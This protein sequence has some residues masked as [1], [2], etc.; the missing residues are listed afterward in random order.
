MFLLQLEAVR[1]LLRG[2]ALGILGAFVALLLSHW[3]ALAP[4]ERGSCNALFR[5]RGPRAPQSKIVLLVVD[6]ATAVRA[7]RMPLPRRY[8]AQ[9]VQKL[10]A[11]GARVIAFNFVFGTPSDD[12]R[13][14]AL[15]ARTV[16]IQNDVTQGLIFD[17]PG[18]V[19]SARA[20]QLL[21]AFS[22]ADRGAGARLALS[23]AAPLPAMMSAR[24]GI[25][26]LNF[27]PEPGGEVRRLPHLIRFQDRL[28]PSL[29]LSAAIQARA[30]SA[31]SWSA[32]P[33]QITAPDG[34]A[35]FVDEN[36]E[37]LVNWLG[38]DGTFATISMLQLLD[39]FVPHGALR[40]ATVM[41]G[42]AR[43]GS[44]SPLATP[45][46]DPAYNN[47]SAL[48]L[49]ANAY[50]DIM[51][52]RVLRPLPALYQGLILAIFS[53]GAG[54]LVARRDALGV[55]GWLVV[56][57]LALWS[58]GVLLLFANLFLPVAAPQVAMLLTG[59]L[60]LGVRQKREAGELRLMHELFDGYVGD[61]VLRL[62]KTNKPKLDGELRHV[63]I[64]FCDIRG[65]SGLA[66][67]LR[68]DPEKLLRLLNDHFEPIVHSLKEHGAY[69]D[70]YVGDLVMAVFGAPVSE[71]ASDRNTRNAVLAGLDVMRIAAR[72]NRE[73]EKEGEPRIDIG[74]GIHCGP[75]VVGD[76][77]TSRKKHYTAI[78]DTVNIASR[79]ERETRVYRTG[80]LVT[81]E[82]VRACSDH[83]DTQHLPWQ[84]VADAPVKG[85]QSAI[86]LFS[87]PDFE[88]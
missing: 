66:E 63:A 60:C 34:D 56:G 1:L 10:R 3:N 29:A 37:T 51:S 22:L 82:V 14:D 88:V 36:G 2:L 70:N 41:I 32:M 43:A 87:H 64:L 7:G 57:T 52:N 53:L 71:Q 46:S 86:K 75:A 20:L 49:Q 19:T 80:F 55:L 33:G 84:F 45:F 42:N 35:I 38:G 23:V 8:Y 83:P 40:G 81:E 85:R 4:L 26:H 5:L 21:P 48:Q 12:L 47:Q 9:T 13:Q 44:F 27:R 28:Y 24:T 61:D 69:V 31:S 16:A 39:G 25:G 74:I 15:V 18:A 62:I 73:R 6:E 59:A 79:V 76:L 30:Q 78:G 77:G 11:E 68:D 54:A 17:S 58:L 65:F 67:G 72:R 50:D